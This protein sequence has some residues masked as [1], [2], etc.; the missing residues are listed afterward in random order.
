MGLGV[1]DPLKKVLV[2]CTESGG[3]GGA[4]V[5]LSLRAR[6]FGGNGGLGEKAVDSFWRAVT[7]RALSPLG[8]LLQVG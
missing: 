2:A 5:A 3:Q 4:P 1:V 7:L 8:L 6:L